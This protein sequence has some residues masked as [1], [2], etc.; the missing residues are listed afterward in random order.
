MLHNALMLSVTQTTYPSGRYVK[1]TNSVRRDVYTFRKH[2]IIFK[3]IGY[4]TILILESRARWLSRYSDC[5][6]AGRSGDRIP[7]GAIF[8]AP[9]QT[10]PEAHSAYCKMGTGSFQG[11]R[12][13][14]CVTLTPYP[15]LVPRSKIE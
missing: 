4:Y 9:V 2:N 12:C 14:R 15:L 10:G 5:L 7:V 6:R 13:G 11:V 3:Q 1:A 8:S